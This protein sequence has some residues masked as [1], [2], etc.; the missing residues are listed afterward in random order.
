MDGAGKRH[1]QEQLAVSLPVRPAY[2]GTAMLTLPNLLTLSRIV[3]VPLLAVFG[4]RFVGT[5]PA[6]LAALRRLL[7]QGHGP[8][9]TKLGIAVAAAAPWGAEIN[10]QRARATPSRRELR[11]DIWGFDTS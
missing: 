8:G 5:W 2:G 3:T 9:C 11:R 4:R 10:R 7:V 6:L 1:S